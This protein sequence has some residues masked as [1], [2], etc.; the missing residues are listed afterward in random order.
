MILI[1]TDCMAEVIKLDPT[2]F[3]CSM[4]QAS[5]EANRRRVR[6][7]DVAPASLTLNHFRD[8]CHISQVV[9]VCKCIISCLYL[10]LSC[11]ASIMTCTISFSDMAVFQFRGNMSSVVSFLTTASPTIPYHFSF[12]LPT[13]LCPALT[14]CPLGRIDIFFISSSSGVL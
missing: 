1:I 10:H 12:G 6:A 3:V 8:Y 5:H 2:S 13:L 9:L 4:S 11:A 7:G 14:L